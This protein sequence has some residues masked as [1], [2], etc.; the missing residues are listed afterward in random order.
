MGVLVVMLR[1][2]DIGWYVVCVCVGVGIPAVVSGGCCMCDVSVGLEGV[3]RG[4]GSPGGPC[5][6]WGWFSWRSMSMSLSRCVC[7]S[8]CVSPDE[9]SSMPPSS[10]P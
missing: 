5:V 2:V 6:L 3:H 4:T 9:C 7:L 8:S 10:G 1:G